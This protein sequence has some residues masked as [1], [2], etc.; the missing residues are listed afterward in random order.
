MAKKKEEAAPRMDEFAG[1]F[2]HLVGDNLGGF[3]SMNADVIAYP[4]IRI[5]QQLS[6][7]TN[8]KKS[9][10]VEGAEA[11]MLYN[12]VT[13]KLYETPVELVVGRFDHY[14]IEWKPERG[15]F[16]GA[17]LPEEVQAMAQKGV[18][19]RDERNRL[20]NVHSKNI[21]ADT[22]VYYV[23]FPEAME[24]GVCLLSLSSTQLKEARRWNRL[25]LSTFIPGTAQ[26]AQ[27]YFLKWRVTTPEMSNDKGDWCG[28]KIDFAG[29]VGPE[30]LQLVHDER[31]ALPATTRPDLALIESTV[32][33]AE[34]EEENS[35]DTSKF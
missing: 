21:F 29:F 8:K 5:L 34:F 6:P 14:F 17:H 7:Q 11:G 13:N 15:G 10:Y 35:V 33:E 27:P 4:F 3:E 32:I 28:F 22:Y 1:E 25:L 16:A 18:L 9:E 26:R 12:N 23:V 24:D 30:T 19:Q 31:K 20:Y 2:S